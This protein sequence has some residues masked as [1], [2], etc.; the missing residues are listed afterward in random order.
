MTHQDGYFTGVRDANIY[1]QCWLPEGEPKAVL[2]VVHGL[3]EH[4]GRYTNVVNHF[5]PKGYA[6]YGIDHFGHGKSDGDRVYV[7][8][9]DD[10]V[11]TLKIY[12]DM[13]QGWQPGQPI[14]LVGH[15]M[16]G[17]IGAAYLLEY[18][19][20]MTGAVLSGPGVKVPDDTSSVT[21]LAA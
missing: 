4:S 13:I 9:F 20:E 6:V 14:F 17:L 11:Q 8:R 5:V 2:V 1:Y 19:D 7:E 10:Y 18:Q 16:G 15:S 12:S 21:I 3:A